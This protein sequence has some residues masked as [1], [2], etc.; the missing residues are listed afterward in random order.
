[1]S[2]DFGLKNI[3]NIN[4]VELKKV[5]VSGNVCGEFIELSLNQIFENKGRD[6]I[7]GEY[8]FPLPDTAVMTGFEV[9][10][11][12]RM[13]KAQIEEKSQSEKINSDA[14]R[15]GRMPLS[16]E[17]IDENIYRI[18]LGKIMRNE[19]VRIKI[20]YIDQLI[21]ED[22][23]LKL[24]IP[25]ILS[26]RNINVKGNQ[27]MLSGIDEDYKLSLNLL[28]EP[29]SKTHIESITHNILV[30]WQD[31]NLGRVTFADNN[32]YLDQDLELIFHE[33]KREEAA[34]MMYEYT[35]EEERKG[36]LYL[37]FI[38]DL[39][40]DD[41]IEK[42][43]YDF[44]IDISETMEGEKLQEAKDALTLCLRNLEEG[45][46]FN[47][48]AAEDHL[49]L[50]SESGKVPYNDENLGK[51]TKWID[52]LQALD[53]AEILDA[54]KYC[55]EE[56]NKDGYSTILIFTDDEG[57]KDEEIVQ[58]VKD[59]IGDNR[60]FTFG[61][62]ASA[63][64]YFINKLAE[65][66]YGKAEF[67]YPDEKIE[68]MVIRQFGRIQ[69]PQ[70]DITKIDYGKMNVISTYPKTIDYLYDLEP[71]SIFAEVNG[72]IEGK[73][74][75]YGSVRN[76]P[77]EY[78]INLDTLDLGEN[79]NLVRK[80]WNR[81]RIESLEEKANA[82]KGDIRK[83]MQDQVVEISKES[84]I[85]SSLTSYIMVEKFEEP[86]LG[87]VINNIIPLI[88]SESAIK[89]LNEAYFIES[90]SFVYK[91]LKK[92]KPSL[93]KFIN[94]KEKTGVSTYTREN[95]LRDLARNQLADGA[96]SDV[97]DGNINNKL[98]NTSIAVLSFALSEVEITNY[99]NQINKSIRY[100]L[101][102]VKESSGEIDQKILSL[103]AVALKAA[104]SKGAVKGAIKLQV[105][106]MIKDYDFSDNQPLKELANSLINL[107]VSDL[108]MLSFLTLK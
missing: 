64:S 97:T 66:G 35:E 59:N 57:E 37:R 4:T 31:N 76:K 63:S 71:F 95:I 87:L 84:G 60:L 42:R 36:V 92:E 41:I 44:L 32:Q 49:H 21:Y 105:A 7:E 83:N 15:R 46:T 24:T 3:N 81:K 108:I 2:G 85:L 107:S 6:D 16:L 10:L 80:V 39:E 104:N 99:L 11:G 91:A 18:T 82:A 103:I 72:E 93:N 67:I 106:D 68:D 14:S 34:G 77:Y 40:D 101:K 20:S 55:L 74:K 52:K 102:T 25:A 29:I 33:E 61:I 9:N 86:V 17:E 47:I 45:D 26:P 22:D 50:F 1:M 56:K 58:F 54:L 23:N 30:E 13:L 27:E 88:V 90:P 65:V 94:K 73:I 28:V 70:I 79:A 43:N 96:F 62:D 78:T 38:P 19:I 98:R 48:V 5:E 12:G 69:N 51:A 8:I 53:D 89:N 100:L 75:I